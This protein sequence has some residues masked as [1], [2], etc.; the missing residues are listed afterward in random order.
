MPT[1][2]SPRLS[3]SSQQQVTICG[4]FLFSR[5]HNS[6]MGTPNNPD[7]DIERFR[8]RDWSPVL[9]ITDTF[10]VP[11]GISFTSTTCLLP[12][13]TPSFKSYVTRTYTHTYRTMLQCKVKYQLTSSWPLP[14]TSSI[15]K[16]RLS[17]Q[18]ILTLCVPS[19]SMS[20]SYKNTRLLFKN[21]NERQNE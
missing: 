21:T 5:W 10:T 20:K 17:Q 16:L 9:Y 12:S 19:T 6:A 2:T 11:F 1:S 13:L 3:I 14:H 15:N 8:D 4:T 18:V 7:S